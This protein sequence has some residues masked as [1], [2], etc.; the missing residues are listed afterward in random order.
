MCEDWAAKMWDGA[1]GNGSAFCNITQNDNLTCAARDIQGSID[2]PYSS[3]LTTVVR[4]F[5]SIFFFLLIPTGIILNTLVIVLVVKYKK[6]W[7]FPRVFV[8]FQVAVANLLL[9]FTLVASLVTTVANKW[10]LGEYMCA[11]TGLFASIA[12]LVRILLMGLYVVDRFIFTYWLNFYQKHKFKIIGSFSFAFWFFSVLISIAMLPGL[13]DC[14]RFAPNGKICLLSSKCNH[15]CSVLVR[16]YGVIVAPAIIVPII[17]YAILF[18][19]GRK[20]KEELLVD[21][22]ANDNKLRE[23]TDFFVLFTALSVLVLV[24]TVIG[25]LVFAIDEESPISYALLVI[26]TCSVL[27]HLIGDPILVVLDEDI[28]QVLFKKVYKKTESKNESRSV[29]ENDMKTTEM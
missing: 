18:Y 14:Y 6:L 12:T 24:T 11:L 27:L 23:G 26:N 28:K 3:T 25:V 15:A 19:K 21:S 8:L 7:S 5:Q 1:E 17:S 13:L 9:L 29:P 16:L 20:V 2:L 22:P 4:I 10:L